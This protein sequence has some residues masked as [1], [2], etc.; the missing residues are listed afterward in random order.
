[1]ME[2]SLNYTCIVYVLSIYTTDLQIYIYLR[3][4]VHGEKKE[5]ECSKC[6]K[7]FSTKADLM[8]HEIRERGLRK[9]TCDICGH[10]TARMCD[11]QQHLATHNDI[12]TEVCLKCGKRYKH[13]TSLMRH[14]RTKHKE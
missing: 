11:L 9:H 4:S 10:K 13:T 3:C 12:L 1:M 7:Q 6:Q 2:K 5:H 8:E 14:M